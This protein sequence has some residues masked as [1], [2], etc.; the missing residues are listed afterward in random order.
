[1]LTEERFAKILAKVN[2]DGS[3]TVAELMMELDASESTV[4]RD[5]M[6]LA[7]DDK[8][9]KVRG[10][11]IALHRHNGIKD[12][13][14][15][16]RQEMH[17]GEKTLIAKY[18]ASLVRDG[19]LVYIDGGTTTGMM[20]RFLTNRE[21]TYVT[22]ALLHAKALAE[23]GMRVFVPGGE[24]K[25]T[26]EVIVGEEACES[27]AKYNFTKGFFGTNG[28]DAD[29]GLTT[30]EV[31][32]STLKM[33]ALGRCRER[34]VLADSSKFGQVATITFGR[35]ADAVVLTDHIPEPYRRFSNIRE[36]AK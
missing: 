24:Y 27:L 32:E 7:A 15:A 11:A 18:A 12:D 23:N 31:R 26:T 5:L 9:I 6:N 10:G 21:A 19:D 30:P 8:L 35:V 33:Q 25:N 14:V 29:A 20:I 16:I 22:N 28:I 3:V 17:T 4:R 13:E 1:M 36:V 34:Y 2:K